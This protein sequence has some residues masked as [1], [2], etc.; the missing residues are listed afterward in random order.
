[1]VSFVFCGPPL[2][3][4]AH[5]TWDGNTLSTLT[6]SVHRAEHTQL[7]TR[8]IVQGKGWDTGQSRGDGGGEGVSGK[9]GKFFHTERSCL[10]GGAGARAGEDRQGGCGKRRKAGPPPPTNGVPG[11]RG[12]Q[13]CPWGPRSWAQRPSSRG[14]GPSPSLRASESDERT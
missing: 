6:A 5:L 14:P 8:K 12:G 10:R 3:A 11:V 1:M 7:L 9:T 2:S 4:Q 13:P